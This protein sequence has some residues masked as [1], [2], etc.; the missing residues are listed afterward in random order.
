M[1]V[2][3]DIKNSNICLPIMLGASLFFWVKNLQMATS[4]FLRE[5]FVPKKKFLKKL[6]KNHKLIFQESIT[7][8]SISTD[9]NFEETSINMSPEQFK[10]CLGILV[11]QNASR[12]K[13][14]KLV[15][16]T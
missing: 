2:D 3:L 15:L 16:Q 10:N 11:T 13:K 4:F 14:K 1:L 9:Y 8:M 5:Y 7:T 6:E 12:K